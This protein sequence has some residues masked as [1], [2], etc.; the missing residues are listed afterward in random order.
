MMAVASL[1]VVVATGCSSS[2]STPHVTPTQTPTPQTSGTPTP[3]PSPTGTGA[4]P[5]PTP[6][7]VGSVTPTPT[8]TP[9]ASPTGTATPTP[10][11]SP[12]PLTASLTSIVVCAQ[13][14]QTCGVDLNAY[15]A[16]GEEAV[17][18][19]KGASGNLS[20]S[21]TGGPTVG[22]VSFNPYNGGSMVPE[23]EVIYKSVS[24]TAT[25]DTL[26]IGETGSNPQ[27]SI[28]V[29]IV[30]PGSD[31]GPD[32]FV[33][34]TT[35]GTVCPTHELTFQTQQQGGAPIV[36]A[37]SDTTLVTIAQSG[38]PTFILSLLR[39]GSGVVTATAGSASVVYPVN[40]PLPTFSTS[41]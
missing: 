17:V 28:P 6:T 24:A 3:T 36:L 15:A 12:V 31:I 38:G 9:T 39:A 10:T 1:A 22:T 14:T 18:L 16:T 23:Y 33:L 35:S 29:S 40:V 4:T 27:L 13:V 25:S 30:N 41:C 37:S 2:P 20:V 11:A 34:A 21:N 5:T 19:V 32:F 8:P 7:P 26:E